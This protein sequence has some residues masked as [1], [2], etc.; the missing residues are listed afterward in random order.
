MNIILIGMR[1]SGKTTIAKLLAKKLHKEFYDLDALVAE[2]ENMPIAKIVYAQGWDYF[3]NK[4]SEIA[5]EISQKANAVI[6]TGGGI[7]LRKKNIDAL[8]RNGKFIF[9]QASVTNLVKRIGTDSNRP[10]LTKE[11]TMHEELKKLWE[12]RKMVY[13]KVADDIVETDHKSL[14]DIVKEILK[15]L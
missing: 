5:E 12:E 8:K 2:K 6:A 4:E 10:R 7:I 11:K 9:L 13:Q 1:G 3:R 14:Q 15:L